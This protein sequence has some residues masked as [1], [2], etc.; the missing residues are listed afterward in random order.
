[1]HSA[2]S[3]KKSYAVLLE[4][5]PT[6]AK[7]LITSRASLESKVDIGTLK[8]FPYRKLAKTVSDNFRDS[9]A[10]HFSSKKV[11]NLTLLQL[12]YLPK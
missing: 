12:A 3:A 2:N 8:K 9:N 11:V 7:V 1:L 4:K 6:R 10:S 5:I